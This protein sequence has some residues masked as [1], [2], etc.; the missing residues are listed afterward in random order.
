M[1]PRHVSYFRKALLVTLATLPACGG[2]TAPVNPPSSDA[3]PDAGSPP[4]G[5]VP[6]TACGWATLPIGCG[7]CRPDC[8]WAYSFKGDP[9]VC[10]GFSTSG[11]PTQCASVCGNDAR[12]EPAD[13]CSVQSNGASWELTCSVTQGPNCGPS[14]PPVGNG[15]RRTSYFAQLGFGAAPR[16]REI[17]VHFARAACM[18]AGSVEAFRILRDEL[19]AHGAPRRLVRAAMRA[20][21]DELRHVRQTTALARRFGEE[22]VAPRP[23]PPRALRSFEEMALE[24]AVEGCVRET[25]SALECA[26]QAEAAADPVVRA[27]MARIARDEMRHLELSWAVNAWAR[28]RLDAEA[29]ERVAAAQRAE[30]DEMLGELA[31]DPNEALVRTGGLP[32]AVQSRS[33]VAAIAAR[34]AA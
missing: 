30:I 31:R 32:R 14:G 11:T 34:I 26:W 12:G 19:V 8:L 15:G 4:P 6:G 13:T 9:S 20:I 3:G 22:P 25:Y 17:G 1:R 2:S 27:T 16:G 33:L 29:R 23:Y 10:T 24:N 7:G 5:P 18:E 28:S 21:R